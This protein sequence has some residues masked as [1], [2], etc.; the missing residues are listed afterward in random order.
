MVAD[1]MAVP[2]K[3]HVSILFKEVGILIERI[4]EQ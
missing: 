4:V 2:A 3:A 1:W